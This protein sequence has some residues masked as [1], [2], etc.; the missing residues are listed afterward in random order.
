MRYK[1]VLT[2]TTP[3]NRLFGIVAYQQIMDKKSKPFAK[4]ET[5]QHATQGFSSKAKKIIG[6]L[7]DFQ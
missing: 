1:A 3:L 2:C 4:A 5:Y 6:S 7:S